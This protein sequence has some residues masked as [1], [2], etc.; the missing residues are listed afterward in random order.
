MLKN[1]IRKIEEKIHPNKKE[2]QFKVTVGN[3]PSPKTQ[4]G[5]EKIER[6][7]PGTIFVWP[8]LGYG[9]D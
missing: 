2:I 7:N 3:G 9:D 5:R 6:A 8:P 4:E 1:R